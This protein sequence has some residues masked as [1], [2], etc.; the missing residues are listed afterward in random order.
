MWGFPKELAFAEPQYRLRVD[1]ARR[2]M[3]EKGLEVL[4]AG[5]SPAVKQGVLYRQ[6][7]FCRN[8][9]R[10]CKH[11]PR[12]SRAEVASSSARR[13]PAPSLDHALGH[14]VRQEPFKVHAFAAELPVEAFVDAVLPRLAGDDHRGLDL[15]VGHPLQQGP[16]DEL[17]AVVGAQIARRAALADQ[18][19]QH[20]DDA[21]HGFLSAGGA[22]RRNDSAN[23]EILTVKSTQNCGEAS[24]TT[25]NFSNSL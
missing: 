11:S 10:W 25:Q 8:R 4:R 2:L 17:R 12:T 19:R 18:A 20:L 24:L 7:K 22:A 1:K 15:L 21:A 3:D 6:P 14:G 16:S 9:G 13:L 5:A 23:L